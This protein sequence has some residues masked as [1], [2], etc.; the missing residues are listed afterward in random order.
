MYNIKIVCLLNIAQSTRL[1]NSPAHSSASRTNSNN[2]SGAGGSVASALS[3]KTSSDTNCAQSPK[4]VSSEMLQHHT[5]R[6]GTSDSSKSPETTSEPTEVNNTLD[7]TLKEELLPSTYP[8]T[9][10]FLWKR[11]K[12]IAIFC[13]KLRKV[14]F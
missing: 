9:V 10:I 4:S 8:G 12:Y 1:L 6:A 14:F 2:S 3:T 5:T 11:Y 7:S 13:H